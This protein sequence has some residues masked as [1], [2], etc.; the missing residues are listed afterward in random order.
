MTEETNE[1]K[2][3]IMQVEFALD[4]LKQFP[5]FDEDMQH[6]LCLVIADK[7][8]VLKDYVVEHRVIPSLEKIKEL[9]LDFY[10]QVSILAKYD[11]TSVTL[12]VV[13]KES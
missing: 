9:Q 8:P 1:E 13:V 5:W 12:E 10:N 2:P 3:I 11:G 6:A 4:E 7:N